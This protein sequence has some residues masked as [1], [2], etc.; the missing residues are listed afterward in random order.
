MC[1]GC[2]SKYLI[3]WDTHD[4]GPRLGFAYNIRQKT[5]IRAAYGIFYGGEE[6]QGGCLLYTSRCV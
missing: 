5:V 2:V 1:R 4:F 3:P 6:Q